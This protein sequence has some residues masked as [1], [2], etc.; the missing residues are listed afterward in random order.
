M[1]CA[2]GPASR[3]GVLPTTIRVASGLSK[4]LFVTHAPGDFQRIFIVEQ[5]GK[6]RILRNG[7]LLAPA[8]LDVDP[9]SACCVERGLLGLAFHPDYAVN[10][11]FYIDYT[12]NLGDIVIAR[13]SV[14]ADP[15]IANPPPDI[16]LR[17]DHPNNTQTHNGGWISFGPDGYLYV[18]VGDAGAFNVLTS[19]AQDIT[20]NLLGKILRIDVNADGFL[21]DPDRN[22]AIPPDNPFVGV[23]GDD[24]IWVYGLRNPWRCAFDADTGDLYIADVGHNDWEEINFRSA[25]SP[26]PRNYGW[27]CMEGAHCTTYGG[28]TC[29]SP[30]L[31]L[32][33]HE[34]G[35]TGTPSNCSII[36]GEV[37]RGCAITELLGTYFYSDYC[38]DQIWSFRYNGTVTELQNRTAAF[39]PPGVLDISSI[40]SFGKDAAGELYI[41]DLSG[42]EVFKIIPGNPITITSADP[43]AGAIDARRPLRNDLSLQCSRALELTPA[44]GV[45]LGW[46]EILLTF[47]GAVKCLTPLDFTVTQQ[48]GISAV[49][50]VTDVQPTDT[51]EVRL[52]FNR[53]L[54]VLAWTTI[55]HLSSG[56]N[57]RIGLLPAD[58]NGDAASGPTDVEALIDT[59]DDGAP[60]RPIWS[61]DIDRSG[62]TAPAD[63]LEEI[64]LLV[65]A[66]TYDPFDGA[67]LPP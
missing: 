18:A 36:G 22:Y 2:A 4:P 21:A 27:K 15:D 51:Q 52:L 31:T 1:A 55:R 6:I 12:D 59:L 60:A 16:V 61:T 46:Q 56:G 40:S 62:A 44:D 47:S 43:P 64:D 3:G 57:V 65:G 17:I 19:N 42:G 32:P 49:P 48:G 5:A 45:P 41:C 63:L 25:G 13:Y 67:V 23:D 8:F 33:I 53:P 7:Q 20:E 28:C 29:P 24:E 66:G 50:L 14:S 54:T 30:A 10:G 26:D 34:Y 11:Q 39:D 58:V 35:R 9:I 38:S 37:Y